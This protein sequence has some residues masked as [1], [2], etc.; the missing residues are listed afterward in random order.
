MF[1]TAYYTYIAI[2]VALAAAGHSFGPTPPFMG[3]W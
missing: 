1:L 3:I 2:M